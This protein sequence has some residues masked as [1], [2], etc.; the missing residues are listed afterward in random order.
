MNPFMNPFKAAYCRIFQTVMRIALPILPYRRPTILDAVTDIPALLKEKDRKKPLLVTDA[1]LRKSGLTASLEQALEGSGLSVSVFDQ[2]CVNPTTDN[3]ALAYGQ[4]VRDGCDCLIGFGGGSPIDC[5]KA[6]GAKAA[7]PKK[8]LA[9]M[10]GILGVRRR[11]PLTIAVPTTAG[12]GSETTLAAVVTDAKTR[13]KYALMDFPLIPDYAV[14]DPQ[15]TVSLPPQL[16]STTGMDALTHATEA[17]IGR[18]TTKETRAEALEAVQIIFANIEQAYQHGDDL[19]ARRAMLRAAYLAGDAFSKSYVGYVHAIAHSLG[20]KYNIAHG[21]ANAVLLPNV[22]EGYGE[23]IYPKLHQLAIAAG[24]A[25][26]NDSD[27]AAAKHYIAEIRR[28]NKAMN[29]PETL[30]GIRRED[31]PEMARYAEK[32]GNPLYPVPVL[33]ETEQ[34]MPYYEQVM[35]K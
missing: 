7:R 32:E 9:Q 35:E 22:L 14:L 16:T 1:F 3:I 20:G 15:L 26:E 4:Y 33:W 27:E 34:F 8:T 5:A 2:V 31:I 30:P 18:S 10:S 23:V 12:T 11:T 17:F 28:L 19:A 13:H 25:S 6:I 24:I 29:I 21:L